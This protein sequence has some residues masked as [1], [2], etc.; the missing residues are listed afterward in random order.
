MEED[1]ETLA[2]CL[3]ALARLFV[4]LLES[5]KLEFQATSLPAIQVEATGRLSEGALFPQLNAPYQR[6]LR[7]GFA[8]A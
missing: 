5:R 7:R 2:E 6:V 1:S 8:G 4:G 3:I